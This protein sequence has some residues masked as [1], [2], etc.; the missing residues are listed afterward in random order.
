MSG[1]ASQHRER[2]ER[3]AQLKAGRRRPGGGGGLAAVVAQQPSSFSG[4][5]I[6]AVDKGITS[7]DA[8]PDRYAGIKVGAP[9]RATPCHCPRCRLPAHLPPR[10][11]PA[12]LLARLADALRQQ[13][14]PAQPGGGGAVQ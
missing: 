13:E 12:G 14:R 7:L 3:L 2:A 6:A 5:K 1:Y 10:S 11:R 9:V 8:L 4:S